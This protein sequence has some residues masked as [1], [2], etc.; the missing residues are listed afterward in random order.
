MRPAFLPTGHMAFFFPRDECPSFLSVRA[1][2]FEI[3]APAVLLI[4]LRRHLL[5]GT[6]SGTALCILLGLLGVRIPGRVRTAFE[7]MNVI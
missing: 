4:T 2:V 6:T 5:R 7:A 1:S 3:T